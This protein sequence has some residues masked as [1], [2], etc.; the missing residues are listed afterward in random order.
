MSQ[1]T[2][3][4]ASLKPDNGAN[5]PEVR[6]RAAE[7]VVVER[8]RQQR[9]EGAEGGREGTVKHIVLNRP[10]VAQARASAARPAPRATVHRLAQ[11]AQ[12]G[13]G[14][15]DV[16][17]GAGETVRNQLAVAREVRRP[18]PPRGT[19]SATATHSSASAVKLPSD[20]GTKPLI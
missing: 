11:V 18:R 16:G 20:D 10:E 3:T 2:D 9:C 19:R 1:Q 13:E 7:I 8:E 4:V 17:Q 5:K 12:A 15:E 6:Q 14:V